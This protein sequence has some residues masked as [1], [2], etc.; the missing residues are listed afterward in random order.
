MEAPFIRSG[1]FKKEK[2]LAYD[3]P[4]SPYLGRRITNDNIFLIS[5]LRSHVY[6][7]VCVC[8]YVYIYKL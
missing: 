6:W 5:S 4:G 7:I 8:V 2:R 3:N 1:F